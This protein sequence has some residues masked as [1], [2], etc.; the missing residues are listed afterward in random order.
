MVCAME[1][2]DGNGRNGQI[3]VGLANDH[4]HG[5]IDNDRANREERNLKR[6]CDR[7]EAKTNH[8]L[9]Y[10]NDNTGIRRL[11]RLDTSP[12]NAI[13]LNEH[14]RQLGLIPSDNPCHFCGRQVRRRPGEFS[15]SY[16]DEPVCHECAAGLGCKL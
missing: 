8:T 10:R 9:L 3:V 15:L 4:H 14:T 6:R 2:I 13:D 1:S 7:Q 11:Y 5:D 12:L 16:G